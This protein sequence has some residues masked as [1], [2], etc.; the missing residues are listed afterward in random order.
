[1]LSCILMKWTWLWS[2]VGRAGNRL[3]FLGFKPSEMWQLFSICLRLHAYGRLLCC[4]VQPDGWNCG[5]LAVYF[6]NALLYASQHHGWVLLLWQKLRMP[7][8]G[9]HGSSSLLFV[10][11][12]KVWYF[13]SESY[14]VMTALNIVLPSKC[15]LWGFSADFFA[16]LRSFLVVHVL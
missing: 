5:A 12:V 8:V 4:I 9:S 11:M 2:F 15:L 6:F 14:K 10:M 1:M 3:L 16:I 7:T 13:V